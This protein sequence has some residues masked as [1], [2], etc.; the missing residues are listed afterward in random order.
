MTNALKTPISDEAKRVV[1]SIA[2]EFIGCLTSEAADM[3]PIIEGRTRDI[4]HEHIRAACENL[5]FDEE[6]RL[7]TLLED[8]QPNRGRNESINADEGAQSLTADFQSCPSM[9]ADYPP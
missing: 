1:Q 3:V 5:G 8:A 6:A 7:L 2:T 4:T 9:S